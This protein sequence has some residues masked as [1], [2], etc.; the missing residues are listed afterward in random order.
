MLDVIKFAQIYTVRTC[1]KCLSVA[2]CG[3]IK[4][5]GPQSGTF[6][7]CRSPSCTM[8]GDAVGFFPEVFILGRSFVE[9][10]MKQLLDYF[11]VFFSRWGK[12][13]YL[14][15][16]I[17]HLIREVTM[18][19]SF[20]QLRVP[21]RSDTFRMIPSIIERYDIRIYKFNKYN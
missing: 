9:L 15:S 12:P 5:A 4:T 2:R 6:F 7:R 17:Y 18:E 16:I 1:K 13:C 19:V 10:P 20:N 14:A 3:S 8:Q 11:N 21:F